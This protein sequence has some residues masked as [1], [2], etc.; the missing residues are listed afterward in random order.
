MNVSE[1]MQARK[2]IRNFLDTPVPDEIIRSLLQKA[3]RSP[4]GGNVQP[5]RIYVVNG[6]TTRR[7]LGHV[8]ARTEHEALQEH[9]KI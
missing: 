9:A 5:W 2:T 6:D 1:A 3:A 7:F 8:Q 4:S